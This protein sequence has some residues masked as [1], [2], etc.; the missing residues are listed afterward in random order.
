MYTEPIILTLDAER[1][2]YAILDHTG[3]TL[4][5][6]ARDVCELLLQI[7]NKRSSVIS[8][9][10]RSKASPCSNIRAAIVV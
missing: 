10:A 1:D 6:G 8:A 7:M 9:E 4:C 5:A 2:I 3:R